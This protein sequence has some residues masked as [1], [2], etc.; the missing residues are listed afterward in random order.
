MGVLGEPEGTSLAYAR[1]GRRFG[2]WLVDLGLVTGVYL[3]LV[4]VLVLTLSESDAWV[5][6]VLLGLAL[7]YVVWPLYCA[8][9]HSR[10]SGQTLG[11]RLVGISVRNEKTGARLSFGRA[12]GRAYF[13][14]LLYILWI[15]PIIVDALWP[16]WDAKR[17]A[18]H[19]KVAD[20]IVVRTGS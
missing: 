17:Q 8:L 6:G 13:M 14:L 16:L 5:A 7:Y 9:C 18:L 10:A 19:D 20:T 2:A 11:K 1:W 15:I 12:L 4:V 3:V